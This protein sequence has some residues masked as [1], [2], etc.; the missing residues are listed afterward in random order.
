MSERA[1]GIYK[2]RP[3]ISAAVGIPAVAGMQMADLPGRIESLTSGLPEPIQP[4]ANA[5]LNTAS[6]A[7]PFGAA[8]LAAAPR[9]GLRNI[10]SALG[11]GTVVGGTAG[12]LTPETEELP[13]G[14]L[15]PTIPGAAPSLD[16]TQEDVD[17]AAQSEADLI[18]Q[19]YNEA[20]NRIIAASQA[21]VPNDYLETQLAI[22]EQ[23]KAAADAELQAAYDA[24]TQQ[25]TSNTEQMNQLLNDFA[26]Q[27]MAEYQA[28][29]GNIPMAGIPGL[30]GEQ[31]GM[32]GV[33]STALGGAGITGMSEA[34]ALAAAGNQGNL[35][36]ILAANI[37]S[38]DILN[39]LAQER[40]AGQAGLAGNVAEAQ[41]AARLADIDRRAS[42][43]QALQLGVADVELARAQA[44]ARLAESGKTT[45]KT[46]AKKQPTWYNTLPQ[47]PTGLDDTAEVAGTLVT[48]GD[49]AN[50]AALIDDAISTGDLGNSS[51]MVYW[52]AFFNDA[53]KSLGVAPSV[54]GK[55]LTAVGRPG[56]PS[57]LVSQ[58]Y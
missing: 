5:A 31:A 53:A 30:T 54:L 14:Q 48:Y 22:I 32:A 15:P 7:L 6:Y 3:F 16:I 34:N 37:S 4:F 23:E 56:T 33:S 26:R 8:R 58:V 35:A 29:A 20:I 21:G 50:I 25:V 18:D 47:A 41:A 38:Q 57:A 36:N 44:L 55:A 45:K 10:L 11:I 46:L 24:A 9:A 17:V 51:P 43:E 40:A 12:L 13:E 49:I 28:T 39:Q 19:A 2:K 52:N 42:A 27:A 1:A